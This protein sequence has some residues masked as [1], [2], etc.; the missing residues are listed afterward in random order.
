M[1][2]VHSFYDTLADAIVIAERMF[3]TFWETVS[4]ES[5]LESLVTCLMSITY[6]PLN[7]KIIKDQR[8]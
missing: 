5:A 2:L 7:C 1:H 4:R 8:A 3:T 6:L